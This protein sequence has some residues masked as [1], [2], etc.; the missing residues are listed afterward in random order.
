MQY[1]T[2]EEK[3]SLEGSGGEEKGERENGFSRNIQFK[4]YM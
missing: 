1:R 3:E 2:Q 4:K